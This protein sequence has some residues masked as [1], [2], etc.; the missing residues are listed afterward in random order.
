MTP[1]MAS[2]SG[3]AATRMKRRRSG[4]GSSLGLMDESKNEIAVQLAAV[5]RQLEALPKAIGEATDRRTSF[6]KMMAKLA[7]DLGKVSPEEERRLMAERERAEAASEAAQNTRTRANIALAIS[8][9]SALGVIA[10][11]IVALF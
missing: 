10:G 1:R 5:A 2:L 9:I 6:E 11:V 3:L 4:G 8:A 7:D